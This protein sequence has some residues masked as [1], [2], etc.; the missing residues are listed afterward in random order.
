[1]AKHLLNSMHQPRRGRPLK[2]EYLP[3]CKS[4]RYEECAAI[5]KRRLESNKVGLQS[6]INQHCQCSNRSQSHPKGNSGT[7]GEGESTR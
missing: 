3:Q 7:S 2:S 5:V 1:M 4:G 6:F